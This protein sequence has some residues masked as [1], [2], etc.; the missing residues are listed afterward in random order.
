MKLIIINLSNTINIKGVCKTK[1]TVK[2]K[3]DIRNV[4]S[5]LKRFIEHDSWLSTGTKSI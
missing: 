1:Y 4:I 2:C 5:K 3:K